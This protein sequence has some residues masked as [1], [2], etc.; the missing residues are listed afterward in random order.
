MK[1]P[2][3][4][5]PARAVPARYEEEYKR[6]A[7][8]LWRNSGRTAT[9]VAAELGIRPGQLYR[10][11]AAPRRPAGAAMAGAPRS[12]AELEE[13]NRRL[14]AENVTLWEQREI[15][16]KSLGIFSEAP[17]RSMPRSQP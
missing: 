12:V 15:L 14:R 13:E 16:K 17:P 2:N 5:K 6:A 9:Q 10:W 1:I 3:T 7:L 4:E 8:E 11:A